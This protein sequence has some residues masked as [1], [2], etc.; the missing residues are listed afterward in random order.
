MCIRD[1]LTIALGA[2]CFLFGCAEQPAVQKPLAAVATANSH[3]GRMPNVR[4][5][6]Y[7]HKETGGVHN[8]LGAYLSGRHVMSAAADW[9]RFPLGT[10]FR[11]CSTREEFIIDD[12]GTALVGTNTIDLYKPTKLEMKRWGVRVVDIDVLQWG[13]EQKSLEVLGPRSKHPQVQSMLTALH[14]KTPST[15]V[16]VASNPPK[17][18]TKSEKKLASSKTKSSAKPEK[19][20]ATGKTIPSAK[21]ETEVASGK[22]KPSAQSDKEVASSKTK[23]SAKSE[24]E[25]ASS[26]TKPVVASEKKVASN[27]TKSSPKAAKKVA[28]SANRSSAKSPSKQVPSKNSADVD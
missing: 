9:S 19:K 1:R 28:S 20:L 12:Y 17:S 11:I 21:S 13:S 15:T 2:I 7:N 23:P 16:M 22:T 8:A 26:K 6:A 10:R 14:T 24:K 27:K 4:T 3:L 5:T 25:V 18:S